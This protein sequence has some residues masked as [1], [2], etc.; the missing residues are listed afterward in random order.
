MH[1][2]LTLKLFKQTAINLNF[3]SLLAN[4]QNNKL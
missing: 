3:T 2:D 1:W 4:I